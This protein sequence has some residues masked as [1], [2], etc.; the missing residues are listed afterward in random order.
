[1]KTR[2]RY[3]IAAVTV[4]AVVAVA[5]G[6]PAA[7]AGGEAGSAQDGPVTINMKLSGKSLKFTG[8]DQV[9]AGQKLRIVNKTKPRKVGPHTFTL[10]AESLIPK[11]PKQRKSCFSP[12]K[13]CMDVALAHK[14]N[15]KTEKVNQP[16]VKAGAP[17]WDTEFT[18]NSK[19]DS[20]YTEKLGAKFSRVV[21]AEAGTTLQY[22][23]VVHPEMKGEIEVVA[24][25]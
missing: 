11:T 6:G 19:G 13:I 8:P 9:T 20:W 3:G 15:P 23:C 14:F 16:V 4:G 1:M 21:S 17:G 7:F 24:A 5:A 2:H 25:P 10:T 22:L 12:G 18:K